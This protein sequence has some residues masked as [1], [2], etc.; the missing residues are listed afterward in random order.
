MAALADLGVTRPSHIQAAAFRALTGSDA[1]H[2]VLADHAGVP[3]CACSLLAAVACHHAGYPM[4]VLA[5]SNVVMLPSKAL[6]GGTSW[7]L[8]S[9]LG[10]A[11]GLTLNMPSCMPCLLAHAQNAK[12]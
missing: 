9:C 4:L 3:P 11:V 6:L 10:Q 2:I 5:P 1:P 8:S 12:A 7:R